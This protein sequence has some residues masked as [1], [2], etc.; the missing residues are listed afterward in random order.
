M[1]DEAVPALRVSQLDSATLDTEIENI[2]GAQLRKVLELIP[3]VDV[4]WLEPEL[5]AAVKSFFWYYVFRKDGASVGQKMM[6]M[7]YRQLTNSILGTGTKWAYFIFTII[8]PWIR[9]RLPSLISWARD[10]RRIRMER[11]LE[12]WES[13]VEMANLLHF[14]WFINRG[15]FR[16]ILERILRIRSVHNDQPYL[17]DLDTELTERE[18]LWH[19]FSDILIFFI[20]LLNYRRFYNF[21]KRFGRRIRRSW[22]KDQNPIEDSAIEKKVRRQDILSICGYCQQTP[23]IVPCHL[24]C[25]HVYCYYCLSANLKADS[26]F[27]CLLCGH[28]KTDAGIRFI[29]GD[30]IE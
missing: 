5:D 27:S 11:S 30:E 7:S 22:T 12:Y 16:T 19:G 24:G 6:D 1:D 20:P 8:L 18:L 15:G 26:N 28:L 9:Q 14:L 23:P 21:M 29:I 4:S 3:G 17:E 25:G 2:L 13:L 10:D